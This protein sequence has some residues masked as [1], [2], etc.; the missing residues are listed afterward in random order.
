MLHQRG[1]R[2]FDFGLV[3]IGLGDQLA[4]AP[5][6][7]RFAANRSRRRLF[8][9]GRRFGRRAWR[10]RR[11]QWLVR[12]VQPGLSASAAPWR[13][14]PVLPRIPAA[15]SSLRRQALHLRIGRHGFHG[16][17]GNA[18]SSRA[19]LG[20]EGSSCPELRCRAHGLRLWTS[21]MI[22]DAFCDRIASTSLRNSSSSLC[23]A[24]S[25]ND[26]LKSSAMRAHLA[27]EAAEL[28]QQLWQVLGT[29][30]D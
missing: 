30:D 9:C 11:H 28:A 20:A 22:E 3:A 23:R 14:M 17:L 10:R 8:R 16:R 6:P 7:R 26:A 1:A 24:M 27:D 18:T 29:D 15:E 19:G 21:P 2:R 12:P 25:S 13:A 5:C 4:L